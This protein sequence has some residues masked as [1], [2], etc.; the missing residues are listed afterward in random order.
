ML[1]IT[2]ALQTISNL[3]TIAIEGD[4]NV[5]HIV[6]V[7]PFLAVRKEGRTDPKYPTVVQNFL[8]AVVVS[9]FPPP[10]LV[11]IAQLVSPHENNI[12]LSNRVL[13]I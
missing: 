12:W 10:T 2:A 1:S 7:D 11:K 13:L 8:R 9:Y 5:E 3:E 6:T 4:W